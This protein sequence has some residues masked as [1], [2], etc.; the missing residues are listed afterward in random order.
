MGTIWPPDLESIT[1]PKYLALIQALREAIAAGE[2][3]PGHRLPPVRNLAW[4]LKIT[5]GTVARAYRRATDDGLLDAA[6]GRGTFIAETRNNTQAIQRDSLHLGSSNSKYDLRGTKTPDFGQDA[7]IREALANIIQTGIHD[8]ADYPDPDHSKPALQAIADWLKYTDMQPDPENIALTYGAQNAMLIALQTILAGPAPVIVTDELV[9]PGLRH[10][11][12]MLRAEIVSVERDTEG[13]I[14]DAL[15]Q[16]CRRHGPQVLVSSFTIHSPTTQT[17]TLERRIAL[18]RVATKYELQIIDDDAFGIF[19]SDTPSMQTIAPERLWYIGALSKSVSTGLRI[20]YLITPTGHGPA[21]RT[22]VLSN[23]YGVSQIICD[24]TTHLIR[25]G[26]AEAIRQRMLAFNAHRSRIAANILGQW[27]I[28][29]NPNVP[30]I[31][32]QMPSGWRASSFQRACEQQNVLV[33]PADEFALI[34]G[35]APN[36]ARVTFGSKLSDS[37]FEAALYAIAKV[38]ETRPAMNEL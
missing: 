19:S 35:K 1:G 38:L 3:T 6:V 15:E 9:Y 18:A 2:L 21:A 32:L 24:L 26:K 31:W 36:A 37:E 7:M 25:S 5:P 4:D 23:C 14:P 16:T 20:G 33:R 11:A 27:N 12:N 30:F 34:D 29:W 10:A 22:T 8:F 13:M 17:T 28:N